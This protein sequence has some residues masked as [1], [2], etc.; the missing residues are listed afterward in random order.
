[1]LC[2]SCSEQTASC[3]VAIELLQCKALVKMW[4]KRKVTPHSSKDLGLVGTVSVNCDIIDI[5]FKMALFCCLVTPLC[6][7]DVS[8]SY[9]L[10]DGLVAGSTYDSIYTPTSVA[11]NRHCTEP[12]HTAATTA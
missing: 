11:W 7:F 10:V 1:M 4:R 3:T 5:H 6:M 9:W 2:I 8:S 12:S